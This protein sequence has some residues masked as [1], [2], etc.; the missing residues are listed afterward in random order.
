MA[1]IRQEI[2]CHNCDRYVQF[3]IDDSMNGKHELLCPNCKH[4]HYRYVYN[5]E[6]SDE[7]WMS[8]NPTLMPNNVYQ[9][10][11]VTSSTYSTDIYLSTSSTNTY[12]AKAWANCTTTSG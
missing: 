3:D 6:I 8:A 12:T 1:I 11:N 9:A 5:G 4:P 2:H 7:R 10:T